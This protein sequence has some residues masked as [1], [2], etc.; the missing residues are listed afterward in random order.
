VS[1]DIYEE[2]EEFEYLMVLDLLQREGW[3]RGG[4]RRRG[5]RGVLTPEVLVSIICVI[6]GSF[7]IFVMHSLFS[8]LFR[9]CFT[10][11][12]PCLAP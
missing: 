12:C 4:D 7:S 5:V 2:L 11:I 3:R 8:V 10:Y 6:N 9:F 1:Q